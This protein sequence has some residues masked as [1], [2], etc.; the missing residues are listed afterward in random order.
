[1][2][3][4]RSCLLTKR[5][6]MSCIERSPLGTPFQTQVCL[7]LFTVI[8]SSASQVLF[9]WV[10]VWSE[11]SDQGSYA[12]NWLIHSSF[13]FTSL[14]SCALFLSILITLQFLSYQYFIFNWFFCAQLHM[15]VSRRAAA[16]LQDAVCGVLL[17]LHTG[18]HSGRVF[19]KLLIS[20]YHFFKLKKL[21]KSLT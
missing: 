17:L 7:E 16:P 8:F 2:A 14:V 15:R 19:G 5:Q 10:V 12:F 20:F 3:Q 18:R 1:M 11:A 6:P 21:V 13:S 9:P 4:I